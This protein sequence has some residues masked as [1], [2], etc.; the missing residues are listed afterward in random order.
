VAARTS[1]RDRAF[2]DTTAMSA[3]PNEA[4]RNQPDP[5]EIA[6]DRFWSQFDEPGDARPGGF[7]QWTLPFL[8]SAGARHV[9]DLGCGPARDMRLLLDQGFVVTGV[10]CSSA[11]VGLAEKAIAQLPQQV[12]SRAKL[13]HAGIVEFLRRIDSSSIDAV[14]AASTYQALS[15]D[16]LS[17]LFREI[18]RVLVPGGLHLWSVRSERHAGSA[19]PETVPPN[20]PALG[21]TVPLRFFSREDTERLTGDRFDRTEC[22]EVEAAPGLFAFYIADWKR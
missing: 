7:T 1:R 19:R 11:A 8:R 3:S 15:D 20:S 18:H 14:H 2:D 13:A 16:E 21:F 17:E 6:W 12:R 5:R 22:Q 4:A 10:D 9:L